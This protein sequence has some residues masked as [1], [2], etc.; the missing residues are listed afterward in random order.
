MHMTKMIICDLFLFRLSLGYNIC[1]KSSGWYDELI[2]YDLSDM[3]IFGARNLRSR[4]IWYEKPAPKIGD[5]KGV[6][7]W[8]RF[9]AFTLQCSPATT[10][11]F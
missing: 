2:V 8:R 10:H 1:Y 5:R 6:D 4:R 3:F 9:L 11:C 7:L